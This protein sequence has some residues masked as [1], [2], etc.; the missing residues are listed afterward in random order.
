MY[1]TYNKNS[2]QIQGGA[3]HKRR[4]REVKQ[5]TMMAEEVE[6]GQSRMSLT[7]ATRFS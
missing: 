2:C 4:T 3:V 6:E 1:E 5:P 7:T